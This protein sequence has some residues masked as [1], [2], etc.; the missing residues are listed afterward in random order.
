MRGE[1]TSVADHDRTHATYQSRPLSPDGA[2]QC[3]PPE[4][5]DTAVGGVQRPSDG[6]YTDCIVFN[7]F[8]GDKRRTTSA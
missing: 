3:L 8:Q 5:L 6:T 2:N 4:A 1:S 7:R